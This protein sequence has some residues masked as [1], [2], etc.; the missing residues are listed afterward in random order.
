MRSERSRLNALLR[1]A[2]EPSQEQMQRF[3]RF[4]AKKYGRKVPLRWERDEAL[5]SGFRLEVG[6]DVYT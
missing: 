6:S 5:S 4:L 2:R 1:S 3:T